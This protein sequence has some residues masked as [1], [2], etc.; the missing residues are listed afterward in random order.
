M[1]SLH[2]FKSTPGLVSSIPKSTAFF[3]NVL[4]HV[5]MAIL[6]IIPF[7][8]SELPVKYLRVPLISS[9][10]LNRDCKVLVEKAKNKISDWKNKSVSFARRLQ[11]YSLWV[12]LIHTYKLKG[13]SFWPVPLKADMSWGWLKLLQLRDLVRPFIW[14]KVGNGNTTSVWFDIWDYYCPLIKFLSPRDIT[15]EGFNLLNHVSDLVLNNEWM[16]PQ[17]WLLKALNLETITAPILDANSH[18]VPCWRDISADMD[19]VPPTL[20]HITSHLQPLAKKRTAKSI[21][22]RLLLAASSYYVWLKHNNRLFKKARRSPEELCDIIMVTSS[23]KD[24]AG[25]LLGWDLS[26]SD[27]CSWI[28]VTCGSRDGRVYGVNITGGGDSGEFTC[29]KYGMYSLYGFGVR[30]KCDGSGF[31]LS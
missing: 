16:W 17:A 29:L 30:K 19:A 25:V 5:K 15:G 2:E 1:E 28:G 22:G 11:L 23:L 20:T 13:R 31:K 7:L 27:H 18:D 8:E 21:L 26:N 6:N 24:P 4:N 3:C 9:R 14:M 12:R 10:L